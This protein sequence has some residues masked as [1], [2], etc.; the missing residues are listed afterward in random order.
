MGKGRGKED[1]LLVIT[2]LRHIPGSKSLELLRGLADDRDSLVK[3]KASYV[4]KRFGKTD[5]NK[6]EEPALA[7]SKEA[8]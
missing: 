3:S 5:D 6:I 7:A 4:I 2:A 8:E 1:K